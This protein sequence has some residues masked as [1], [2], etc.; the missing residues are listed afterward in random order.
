M[1]CNAVRRR[2]TE[3]AYG[4]L[5]ERERTR[6]ESHLASCASCRET[7]DEIE[8]ILHLASTYDEES[9]PREAYARLRREVASYPEKQRLRLSVIRRPIP[10]YAAATAIAI[11]AVLSG[12][13]T[14][15]EMARLESMNSLLSDSLRALNSHFSGRPHLE[16]SDSATQDTLLSRAL[17]GDD[18]R[19]PR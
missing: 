10:A 1:R 3:Y 19:D 8:G 6:I 4:D 2:L 7:A 15:T 12:I 9:P 17:G 16:P 14:R 13:S 5:G 18:S 11:V